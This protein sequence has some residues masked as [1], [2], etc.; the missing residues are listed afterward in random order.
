MNESDSLS[1]LSTDNGERPQVIFLDA[2]GTLFGIRGSVGAVYSVFAREAGVSVAPQLLNEAFFRSFAASSPPAF[3]EVAP[4]KISE[5]E[6]EWWAAIASSTFASVGVLDQFAD[7]RGFFKRLYAHF[8]TEKP[9]YIYPDV[10]P[11]LQGWRQQGIELGIIS[12]FDTRLYSVIEHLEIKDFFTT[13]TI[14]AHVGAA[15]P[16][17]RIFEAALKKHNYT[18][19]QAWHIGDSQKEDYD[20]AKQAGLKPFLLERS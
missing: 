2:V 15:K 8:A 5:R 10:L 13:V 6:F 3:P 20:G 12:N 17:R 11:A 9:W 4:E 19:N 14:S 7:F 18:P 1:A 16:D